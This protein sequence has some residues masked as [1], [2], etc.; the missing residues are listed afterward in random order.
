LVCV[1]DKYGGRWGGILLSFL[2][3]GI[4][5]YP[6][7]VGSITVLPMRVEEKELDAGRLV[8]EPGHG[9]PVTANQRDDK[10]MAERLDDRSIIK[11]T[12]ANAST[13]ACS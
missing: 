5:N 7:L 10:F 6:F 3:D 2:M 1:T 4:Y 13:K 9:H 11:L 12:E 8:P